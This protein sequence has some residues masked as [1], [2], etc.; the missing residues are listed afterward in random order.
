M[1][2][3]VRASL[4]VASFLGATAFGGAILPHV[5]REIG[6]NWTLPPLVILAVAWIVIVYQWHYDLF[7]AQREQRLKDLTN[8][9]Y[10]HFPDYRH[11][12]E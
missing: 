3:T 11:D 9:A 12:H 6:W 7:A 4:A 1:K 8:A 10:G 5:V 2:A